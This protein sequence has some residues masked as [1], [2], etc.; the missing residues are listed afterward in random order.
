[1]LHLEK[2][3]ERGLSQRR[4]AHEQN[5]KNG[6]QGAPDYL[7]EAPGGLTLLIPALLLHHLHNPSGVTTL[8]QL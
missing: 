8:N 5:G 1:M 4:L 7:A 3:P 6:S 2:L